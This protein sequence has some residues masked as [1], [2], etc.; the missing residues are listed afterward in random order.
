[1]TSDPL[2]LSSRRALLKLPAPLAKFFAFFPLYTYPAVPLSNKH[3]VT[4]PTLWIRSPLSTAPDARDLLSADVECLKWQA[5]LALRGL[6][7]VQVRWDV[8][9]E[10]AL[11]ERLPNLQVP[12]EG[13]KDVDGEL[14]AAHNFPTWL[15]KHVEPLDELEGY[16]DVESRD[17]SHAWVALLEGDIQAALT[18]AQPPPSFFSET[19]LQLPPPNPSRAIETLLTPPPAPLSGISSLI[20]PYGSRVSVSSMK[21]RYR[22]AISSLSE[23]LGNDKWFLGSQC[24]FF[25]HLTW[26]AITSS[27]NH[28]FYRGPTA[29]DALAFA[30]IRTLMRSSDDL[31]VEVARRVN[32]VTW[33]RRVY[34]QVRAAFIPPLLVTFSDGVYC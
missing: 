4:G 22:E 17:E 10:G 28:S 26:I 6:S 2:L 33:E 13:A 29:L 14:L 15:E 31:R 32:L 5:H 24:V 18:L 25:A 8:A 34:E 11:G 9:P 21:L 16:K 1:M 23:R 20:R 30:C 19:V 7:R 12:S 3:A 27:V